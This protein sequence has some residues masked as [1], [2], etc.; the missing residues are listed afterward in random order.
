MTRVGVVSDVHNNVVALRAALDGLQGCDLVL[1]L[2]DLVS[3][4]RVAPE[5]IELAQQAGI[6]GIAGNHEKSIFLHPGSTLKARVAAADLAYLEALP[7][8]RELEIDGRRVLVAH[9][10]PWDDPADYHCQYVTARDRALLK[11]I[12]GYPADVVLLG[13]THH[14]MSMRAEGSD[15]VVVN[16]GSCGES[17]AADRRLTFAEL[18]FGA[19]LVRTYRLRT[20]EA[21]E[22]IETFEL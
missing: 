22:V 8:Q 7:A 1:S 12:G 6:V 9:G 18:D 10:A 3:D 11:R 15:L 13:H 19:G 20:G 5:I 4:Y 2:G 21:A 16:P 14:A 17:R